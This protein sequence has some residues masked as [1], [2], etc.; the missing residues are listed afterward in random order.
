MLS[1]LL[2]EGS[3][4]GIGLVRLKVMADNASAIALYRKFGFRPI[5]KITDGWEGN[6]YDAVEMVLVR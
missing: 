5:R 3:D 4:Q 2:R 1:S 6:V